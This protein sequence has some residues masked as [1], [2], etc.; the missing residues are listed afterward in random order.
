MPLYAG[1][2]RSSS[3][4]IAKLAV[5]DNQP[6]GNEIAIFVHGFQVIDVDYADWLDRGDRGFVHSQLEGIF[7]ERF[8]ARDT[9][10]D[11]VLRGV[12][13]GILVEMVYLARRFAAYF[14]KRLPQTP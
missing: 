1:V 8:V 7:V 2:S 10:G 5:L 14:T 6:V 4:S 9:K 3:E 12:V 13:V 11:K